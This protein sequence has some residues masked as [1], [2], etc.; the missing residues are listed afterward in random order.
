MLLDQLKKVKKVLHLG[1]KKTGVDLVKIPRAVLEKI[2]V[3]PGQGQG[4]FKIFGIMLLKTDG[5]LKFPVR[6]ARVE[7]VL[8]FL[9]LDLLACIH[10]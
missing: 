2:L 6:L 8:Q 10:A 9:F 4:F 1:G 7:D 5:D 3:L